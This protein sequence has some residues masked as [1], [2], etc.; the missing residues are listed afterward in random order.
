M[1]RLLLFREAS[2]MAYIT[3]LSVIPSLSVSFSLMSVIAPLAGGESFYHTIKTWFLRS[4][5]ENT[6]Q[7]IT[8][9]IDKFRGGG[10]GGGH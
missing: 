9:I 10:G 6:G 4:L 1:K 2:A 7:E 8:H 5:S 3:L